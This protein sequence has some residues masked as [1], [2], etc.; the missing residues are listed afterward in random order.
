MTVPIA[1]TL[2]AAIDY[3]AGSP[4]RIQ[5]L[6]KVYTFAKLIGTEEGLDPHTM[7]ILEHTAA[8]HDVGIRKS[9]E[10]YGT[11]DGKRQEELGPAEAE[12]I[13]TGL[14]LPRDVVDRACWLVAHHHT[15]TEIQ[16]LDYQILVEAD[17]LVNLYEKDEPVETQRAVYQKIFKTEA[18]KRLFRA[19]FP[20][21]CP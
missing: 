20:A 3:D 6:I 4:K 7:L 1:R 12:R 11:Y 14:G 17:F 5:H 13:L 10:V 16:G 21:A 2:A 18:G 19:H 15:Y 9:L 8:V